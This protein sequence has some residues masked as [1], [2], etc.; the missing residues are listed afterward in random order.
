MAQVHGGV[1]AT[2]GVAWGSERLPFS[3]GR[4]EEELPPR[5]NAARFNLTTQQDPSGSQAA[6]GWESATT[7]GLGRDRQGPRGGCRCMETWTEG[8]VVGLREAGLPWGS[9]AMCTVDSQ[10][11]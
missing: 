9:A 11:A 6:S 5:F 8:T 3:T 1:R 2:G 10:S 4:A 7:L